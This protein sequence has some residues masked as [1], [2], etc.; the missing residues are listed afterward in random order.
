MY[1]GEETNGLDTDEY[2]VNHF[3]L[4]AN[5]FLNSERSTT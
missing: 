3:D 1:Q 5:F 4:I 2:S